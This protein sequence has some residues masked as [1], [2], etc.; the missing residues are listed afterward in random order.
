MTTMTLRCATFV[1]VGVVA[2]G[3]ATVGGPAAARHVCPGPFRA[4]TETELIALAESFEVPAEIATE[5][6]DDTNWDGD[7]IICV[8]IP[9]GGDQT[10][11]LFI[12]NPP[13]LRPQ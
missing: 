4:Y 10:A 7:A 11:P 12:D 1:A 9:P 3:V 13:A 2:V 5:R 8:Q 6:F